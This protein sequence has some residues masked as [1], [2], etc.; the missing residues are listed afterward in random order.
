[1]NCDAARAVAYTSLA[2]ADTKGNLHKSLTLRFNNAICTDL[3]LSDLTHD[4]HISAGTTTAPIIQDA[5][6]LQYV[7][8]RTLYVCYN[9]P[10]ERRTQNADKHKADRATPTA[11]ND[12]ATK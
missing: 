1:M 11:K 3:L 2:K 10:W 9:K 8:V 4:V 5:D 12:C 6:V 7:H